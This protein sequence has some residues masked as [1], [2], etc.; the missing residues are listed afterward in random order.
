MNKTININ[1]AGIIFHVDEEAYAVLTDYLRKLKAQFN[2]QEG[3]DEIMM[4]IEARLAEL[5]TERMGETRQ[6]ISLADVE[7]TIEIMGQPEDYAD[8]DA[9]EEMN[10]SSSGQSTSSDYRTYRAPRRLYRDPDDNILGGVCSGLAAYMNTDPIW[11]RLA[12]VA[13]V[14]G[15]GTGFWL[16]IILWIVIPEAKTTAQKLQMRGEKINI[17]NIEKSVREELK[18]VGESLNKLGKDGRIKKGGNRIANAVEELVETLLK[19]IGAILKFVFKLI[20]IAFLIIAVVVLVVLFSAA[21]GHGINIQGSNV[22]LTEIYSYIT[23]FLPTGYSETFVWTAF[24]LLLIAP[25]VG[26]ITASSKILFNYKL[27]NKPL[28]T[29]AGLMSLSGIVMFLI[30]GFASAREFEGRETDTSQFAVQ[31][32]TVENAIQ[33]KLSEAVY[34]VPYDSEVYIDND[35]HIIISEVDLDVRRTRESTPYVEVTRKSHGRSRNHASELASQ[36]E[37][38]IMQEGNTIFMDEFLRV[39][40]DDRFRGQEVDV[41]L[42]LPEGYSVYLDYSVRKIIND[43]DNVTDTYDPYMVEHVWMMTSKGLACADCDDYSKDKPREDLENDEWEKEWINEAEQMEK[44][45]EKAPPAPIPAINEVREE[46]PQ[47]S[48]SNITTEVLR[49]TPFTESL[50]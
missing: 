22:G 49:E 35:K 30:L 28:I 37:F 36:I 10:G 16:Y 3:G 23:A 14:I 31:N 40:L 21:V 45:L 43:I 39:D 32:A 41:V 44:E 47:R 11:I 26:L 38:D 27:S 42:Y 4:D 29:L 2:R 25:I 9:E 24:V 19:I 50:I 20:G 5:F 12:F 17:S 46:L 15:A 7:A 1:L 34:D 8:P 33:L 48:A 6:V 18:N 13:L